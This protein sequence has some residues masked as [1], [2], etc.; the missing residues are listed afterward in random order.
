[1]IEEFES[2]NNRIHSVSMKNSNLLEEDVV[3]QVRNCFHYYLEIQLVLEFDVEIQ[4]DRFLYQTKNP[5][6]INKIHENLPVRI[7]WN[8]CSTL[9]ESNADV[10]I[11][12]T[13]FFSK[14]INKKLVYFDQRIFYQQMLSLHH[15]V[16]NVNVVNQ[17]YYPQVK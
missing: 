5:K 13:P 1:M 12:D 9:V 7:V 17:I 10:S 2:K 6:F 4:Y 14:I 16:P 8:A 15:L 3:E 11:N